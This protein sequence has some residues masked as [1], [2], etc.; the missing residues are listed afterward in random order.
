MFRI[1]SVSALYQNSICIFNLIIYLLVCLINKSGPLPDQLSCLYIYCLIYQC[2]LLSHIKDTLNKSL[3]VV[4]VCVTKSDFLGAWVFVL[5]LARLQGN[6]G[7]KERP[8]HLLSRI[9]TQY[10][11]RL[12]VDD[13]E[14]DLEASKPDTSVDEEGDDTSQ[15][16]MEQGD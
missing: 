2:V 1:V 12:G 11:T 13:R 4:V 5:I 8:T 7:K 15:Q 3:Y 9:Q 6:L 16:M 10:N 14:E